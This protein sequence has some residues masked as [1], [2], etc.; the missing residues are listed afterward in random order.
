MK[1]VL[2]SIGVV[3][4]ILLV[5]YR[6]PVRNFIGQIHWAEDRFGPGG[7]FTL[8][9]LAGILGFFFSLTYMVGG[10]D[11]IFGDRGLDFFQA[12]GQ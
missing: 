12:V 7:T 6:V 2:G 1:I 3:L 9:L 5:V 10:F 11:V 4:S 8:L